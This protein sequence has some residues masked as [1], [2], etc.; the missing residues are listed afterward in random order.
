MEAPFTE[1]DAGLR[2]CIAALAGLGVGLEREWSGHTVGP[3]ARFAGI[4][5]F[6]LLGLVGGIGGLFFSADVPLAGLVA[7]CG[8][9]ALAVAAYV[10]T[11][12]R[13]NS[14]IDGTTEAAALIVLLLGAMAGYG[15]L[16]LS[17]GVSS[18]VVLALLEKSRLHSFVRL[19]DER[20]LQGGLQFAVM[21]LVILPLLPTGPFGSTI[22][23]QPRLLW[24][25]V[26]VFSGLNFVGFIARRA[27]GH[28]AGYAVAGLVGGLVSSTAVTLDFSHKSREPGALHSAL[29]HGVLGACTVLIPRVLVVSTILNAQVGLQLC[30]LLAAPFIAGLFMLYRA[31]REFGTKDVVTSLPLGNPL[32][33]RAAIQM[34][35][36]FQLSMSVLALVSK[37]WGSLGIYPAAAVLG[38]A[39]MDA[40]TLSMS[41]LSNGAPETVAAFAIAIGL[42]ANT[43]LKATVTLIVGS[44]AFRV[45][46]A[47]R[48]LVQAVASTLAMATYYSY[49][50]AQ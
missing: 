16:S 6:L 19:V 35:I 33:L 12:V 7:L 39:D 42:L 50:I 47:G 46:A 3:N 38:L 20:E 15:W 11:V 23:I 14:E 45:K 4:R 26:L 24:A 34:A 44:G 13:P 1:A 43:L 18:I 8:G 48:L 27:F 29:A 2:L 9:V 36:L 31:K 21:A 41:R 40:L 32:R 37:A 49:A 28:D 17:A 30:I 5:T 10:A 25:M 22:V